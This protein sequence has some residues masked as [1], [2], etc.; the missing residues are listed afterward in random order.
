MSAIGSG[1]FDERSFE[2]LLQ[3]LDDA[4]ER[5]AQVLPLLPGP[6]FDR[7]TRKIAPPAGGS[8]GTRR[9]SIR[10]ECSPAMTRARE[11]T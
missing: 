2:R 8:S 9:F 6:P 10:I 4:R 5:G 7:G 3:A 11:S 1:G